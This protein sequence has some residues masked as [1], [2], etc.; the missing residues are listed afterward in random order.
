ME[1]QAELADKL[2]SIACS[3]DYWKRLHAGEMKIQEWW[4]E[5]MNRKAKKRS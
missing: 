1:N 2:T 4:Q 5:Y 3:E